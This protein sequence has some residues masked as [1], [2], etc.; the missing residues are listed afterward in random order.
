M[1][2]L[3]DL[4]VGAI[5]AWENLAIPAGWQVCDGT[6]DTPDLRD[7]FVRGASADG[8]VRQSGGAASHTHTNPATSAAT[9]HNHGGSASNN[10]LNGGT[11]Y[12]T[13]GTGR[14]TASAGHSH[15][16]AIGI[17]AGGGHSHTIGDTSAASSLPRYVTRVFIRR[18]V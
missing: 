6:N 18:M 8:D 13:V 1:A 9:D 7:R 12:A 10:A 2:N 4:P 5:I 16:A 17:S 11:A 14:T 3:I 15:N